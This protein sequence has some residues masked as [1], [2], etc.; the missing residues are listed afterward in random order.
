MEGEDIILAQI[1]SAAK[2][3]KY[4]LGLETRDFKRGSLKVASVIRTE[5][6]FTAE[7]SLVLYTLGSVTDLK[8]KEVEKALIEI[9]TRD[10]VGSE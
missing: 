4:S 1:T 10:A 7:K 3:N 5:K 2:Q 8:R 9:F 6:L